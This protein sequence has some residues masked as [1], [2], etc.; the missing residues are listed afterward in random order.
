MDWGGT[1]SLKAW[2]G[3]RPFLFEAGLIFFWDWTISHG[4]ALMGP[5]I[6]LFVHS[7][8]RPGLGV[9]M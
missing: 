3:A 1:I 6:S 2:I 9:Y 8:C 4:C 5:E 7:L